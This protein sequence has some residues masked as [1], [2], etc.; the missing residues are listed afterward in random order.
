MHEDIS[1]LQQILG[2]Q[3]NPEGG[4]FTARHAEVLLAVLHASLALQ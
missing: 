2:A 1:A 4:A 3:L